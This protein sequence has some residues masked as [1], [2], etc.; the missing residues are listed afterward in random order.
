MSR[1]M[2]A[3]AMAM[4]GRAH[5]E[6][7]ERDK[8]EEDTEKALK[9]LFAVAHVKFAKEQWWECIDFSLRA[10]R[11]GRE[12]GCVEEDL[13]RKCFML[14]QKASRK[15]T[16]RGDLPNPGDHSSTYIKNLKTSGDFASYERDFDSALDYFKEGARLNPKEITFLYKIAAVKLEQGEYG[17]RRVHRVLHP[18]RKRWKREWG[19]PQK[20]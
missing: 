6:R 20:H 15:D 9:F 12:N 18:S 7:G 17:I 10:C 13:C 1:K 5:K 8:F 2:V 16:S 19:R 4:R 14:V 11:I 3:K